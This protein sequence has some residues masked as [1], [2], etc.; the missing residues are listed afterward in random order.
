MTDQHFPKYMHVICGWPLIMVAFGGAVGGGLGGLAYGIN[1][2]IFKKTQSVPITAI[3]SL[4]VGGL[5]FILWLVIAGVIG[6]A[7]NSR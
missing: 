2:A 4:G 5:A 1:A 3:A 6:T 7:I